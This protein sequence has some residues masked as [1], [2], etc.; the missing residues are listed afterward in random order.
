MHNYV[1]LDDEEIAEYRRSTYETFISILFIIFAIV[2]FCFFRIYLPYQKTKPVSLNKLISLHENEKVTKEIL[3]KHMYSKPFGEAIEPIIELADAGNVHAQNISCWAILDGLN[4]IQ[5]G[6]LAAEYCHK[7]AAQG[8]HGAQ[9]NLG[10]YYAEDAEPKNIDKAIE[11]YTLAAEHRERAAWYL[12]NIYEKYPK[13]IRNFKKAHKYKKL[14]ADMGYPRAMISLAEDYQRSRLGL[15]NNNEMALKYYNL[16]KESGLVDAHIYLSVFYRDA[17]APYQDYEKMVAHA[18]KAILYTKDPVAFDVLGDA[19]REGR[20]VEKNIKTA[21]RYYTIAAKS[22]SEYSVLRLTALD[23]DKIDK[24]D[25]GFLYN[26]VRIPYLVKNSISHPEH[27]Q[28]VINL[29]NNDTVNPL[30]KYNIFEYY[31]D[32]MLGKHDEGYVN[33]TYLSEIF[34]G[35]GHSEYLVP[36]IRAYEKAASYGS[37]ESAYQLGLV[38]M[39]GSGVERNSTK[40]M[41]WISEAMDL[42]FPD[43]RDYVG[44]YFRAPDNL[45]ERETKFAQNALQK[46]ASLGS[47]VAAETLGVFYQEGVGVEVDK[48]LAMYWFN[49]ADKGRYDKG[50]LI[51]SLRKS[52]DDKEITRAENF[53]ENCKKSEFLMCTQNL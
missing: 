15:E 11:Y 34:S 41:E 20:G 35:T 32:G 42:G 16:A 3:I 50:D 8:H 45:S 17:A 5:N 53:I 46:A 44:H 36:V 10:S 12:S 31:A 49:H 52:M 18:Q 6:P 24:K 2:V 37:G 48:A 40:S 14:A 4:V 13:P 21:A 30:V 28:N 27:F 51:F 9:M 47:E 38:Y 33:L 1:P 25:S 19:Y 43:N 22:G 26:N 7:A 39:S 23:S 29:V